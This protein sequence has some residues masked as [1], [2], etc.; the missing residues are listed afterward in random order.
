M[1]QVIPVQNQ[2]WWSA[3]GRGKIGHLWKM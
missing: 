1:G 3:N 2:L